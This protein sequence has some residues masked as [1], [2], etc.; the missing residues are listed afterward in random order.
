MPELPAAVV[1]RLAAAVGP[2]HVLLDEGTTAGYAVD[3]TGR[4]RGRAAAVVRPGSTADVAAVLR[5]CTAAGVAVVP[6][7]GNTGLVGGGVPLAGEVVLSTRRLDG[8]GPVDALAAQV[9]VGA[10]ATL[11]AVQA[12]AAGASLGVG[13]DL[14]ARDGATIGG[15]VA[16][17]AGGLAVVRHGPMRAS[18]AGVEAVL[19][20]GSVLSRLGGLDKDN[21]GYDLAG[22]LCGSE[23]TLAVVTAVRLRLVAVPAERTTALV[24]FTDVAA[25]MAALAELRRRG[26][27][28]EAAELVLGD[29]LAVAEDHLGGPSPV[30][31]PAVL[32]VEW[33]PP[34]AAEEVL[35]GAGGVVAV[36]VATDSSRR[37]GLWR[38]REAVTEAIS[39]LGVPHK[40]D[41]ALPPAALATFVDD[42]RARVAAVAPGS[43]VALFG[44]AAEG[45]LHVNVV[46]PPPEDEAVD[47]AVLGLVVERGGS[48]S[49]EHGIGTAKRR[50][51]ARNRT[52]EEVAAMRA[53]KAALDPAGTLN[54]NALF[55]PAD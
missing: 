10:G 53:V 3:W 28:L 44:H 19:S 34:A 48:I 24:G 50:W 54:P 35:A 18:V 45:N 13:V 26:T 42:V 49:A 4:Y 37:A 29:A 47:D 46:G 30:S 23:G 39:A 9:T 7:G 21:T 40:L 22:L 11:V 31:A 2:A 1:E 6:Q 41:I 55:S 5:V 36:A 43:T 8:I 20:D 33:V 16:T 12:A 25:A 17:N 52:P 51:L 27:V 32:L 38:H 14:A 15:M